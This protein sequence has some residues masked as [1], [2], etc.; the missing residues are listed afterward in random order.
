MAD[1]RAGAPEPKPDVATESKIQ[2]G[3]REA[4]AAQ[5]LNAA[6]DHGGA[7][8]YP[9]VDQTDGVQA[10][11]RSFDPPAPREGPGDTSVPKPGRMGPGGDPAEGKR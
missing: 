4:N 3:G 1:E 10:E 6:D 11:S 5:P 2:T 7:E 9:Q 8:R